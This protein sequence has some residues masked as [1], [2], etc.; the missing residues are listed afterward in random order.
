MTTDRKYVRLRER[1]RRLASEREDLI[2]AGVDPAELLI[3]LHPVEPPVPRGVARHA[4]QPFRVVT[5]EQEI[6]RD[7]ARVWLI[8]A[9]ACF[10]AFAG[11]LAAMG[12]M[13]VVT[14]APTW[15]AWAAGIAAVGW[16]TGAFGAAVT[17]DRLYRS[18]RD[19]ATSA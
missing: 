16:F 15:H 11:C 12:A 6:A 19:E 14:Q 1:G 3:P 10:A 7:L 9:V 4:A 8:V 5:R 17:T 13:L 18:A 2:A